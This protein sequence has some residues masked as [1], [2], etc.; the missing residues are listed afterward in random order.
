[1]LES[2]WDGH[3]LSSL[4][5][6][7]WIYLLLLWVW[8]LW[9]YLVCSWDLVEDYRCWLPGFPDPSHFFDVVA[10]QSNR[11][12]ST[13]R[14]AELLGISIN[15]GYL[16]W[17]HF[18]WISWENTWQYIL[19]GYKRVHVFPQMLSAAFMDAP[20]TLFLPTTSSA[21]EQ[22][23]V[24]LGFLS[25]RLQSNA[26]YLL[27]LRVRNGDLH[28]HATTFGSWSISTSF[29]GGIRCLWEVGWRTY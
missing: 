4:V 8:V 14:Y 29:A 3:G 23:T 1:M 24:S 11:G 12:D 13:L 5:F 9:T 10:V 21:T 19:C 2:N 22:S 28:S 17:Y 15:V 6:P 25:E 26:A 27:T 16:Q 20:G 7:M 18:F